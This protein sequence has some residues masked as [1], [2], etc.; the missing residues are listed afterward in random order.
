[1]LERIALYNELLAEHKGQILNYCCF[2][3]VEHDATRDLVQEVCA[4]LWAAMERY[5]PAFGP[6]QRNRWVQKVMRHTVYDFLFRRR[7]VATLPLEG[8]EGLAAPGD[9]AGEVLEELMA[10]LTDE[11][12]RLMQRLFEGYTRAEIAQEYG[13]QPG[14]IDQRVARITKKMKSIYAKLYEEG[15]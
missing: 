2:V 7:R 4:A 13:L 11:E 10:Y 5:D 1:M 14:G 8:A 3:A 6:R 12:R 15:K 9:E